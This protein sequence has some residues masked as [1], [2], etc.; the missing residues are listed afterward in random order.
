MRLKRIVVIA[1]VFISLAAQGGPRTAG[2]VKS[3]LK[4]GI[5]TVT[6]KDG[7][8]LNEKAPNSI[9]I[10]E[11]TIKPTQLTPSEAKFA[12]LPAEF[13]KGQASLYI[14]DDAVTFCEMEVLDLKTG[15][16]VALAPAPEPKA[17]KNVKKPEVVKT[18]KFGF[19]ENDF[20]YALNQAKEQKKLLLVDFYARWCPGC[21]R[22]E[23]EMFPTPAFKKLTEDFVKVKIDVDRFENAVL[24][25]KF[26][27]K[28]VP[29]LLVLT[30][31]QE[32]VDR[33]YDYQ[34]LEV[35]TQFFSSVQANPA[36]LRELAQKARDKDP[37][38]LLQFG[39]R[40][41][42]AG[43]SGEALEVLKQIK[44][45]PPELLEAQVKAYPRDP[46]VLKAAI[47]AEPKSSRSLG[48]RTTLADV[49]ERYDEKMKIR[50]EGVALA[51]E[52]LANSEK[53]KE[54]IKTDQMGEFTDYEPFLIAL[55]RAEL[56]ESSEAPISEIEAAWKKAA[57]V[58]TSVRIPARNVGASMRHL[59]VL[60][61]AKEYREADKLALRLLKADP[62]NPELQRRRLRLL[63]ELKNFDGAIK[64]GKKVIK[65]SY[66]RN[67][68]WAAEIVAKAY[69]QT[70]H[71]KQAKEFIESYLS[72]PEI[73]WPHMK[74]TKKTFEELRGR[75]GG[76]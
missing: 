22:M 42:S 8:H 31:D 60:T 56:V 18:N 61:K 36:S 57:Q 3:E 72:R 16:S 30:A 54:A 64:L 66:G 25:E 1:S 59:I 69:V 68:F 45:P 20:Q 32:E 26:V 67:E 65:N 9:T 37:G 24:G 29:T 27:I 7:F 33:L 76:E 10:D 38:V 55:M 75:Y 50:N 15:A 23:I 2:S 46:K 21:V 13:K 63:V 58:G 52:L 14:C 17:K 39:K 53:L 40:L 5:F 11:K 4:D 44:P 74:E 49:T 41:L 73:D 28:G 43:R 35:L 12:G 70:E 62:N 48:W 6:M 19:I 71:N 47:Q 51:D 34:S